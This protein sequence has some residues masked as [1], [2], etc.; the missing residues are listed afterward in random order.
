MNRKG[1]DL[2]LVEIVSANLLGGTEDNYRNVSGEGEIG[3]PVEILTKDA[4]NEHYRYD[5]LL[6][7]E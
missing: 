1:S 3:A 4:S 2:G 5:N 7:S 6:I